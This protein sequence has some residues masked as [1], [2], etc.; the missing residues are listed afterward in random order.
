[1]SVTNRKMFRSRNARNKLNQMG[2][3]M[4]S[5]PELM[6]TVQR[7]NLGGNVNIGTQPQINRRNVNAGIPTVNPP[8][9]LGARSGAPPYAQVG[10]PPTLPY[11]SQI[12]DFLGSTFG[13]ETAEERQQRVDLASAV[14]SRL[15]RPSDARIRQTAGPFTN[16]TPGEKI[17]AISDFFSPKSGTST[18]PP[19]TGDIG[20]AGTRMDDDDPRIQAMIDNTTGP[21]VPSETIED[22]PLGGRRI[23]D[24]AEIESLL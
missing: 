8:A 5:S 9:N 10:R 24:P 18:A 20:S 17:A 12:M 4:A 3:I 21:A 1:M 7:F 13:P 23:T 11:A 22:F 16:M 14:R 19:A 6:N 15:S 2:G